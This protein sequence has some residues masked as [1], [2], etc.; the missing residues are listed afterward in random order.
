MGLNRI[1]FVTRFTSLVWSESYIGSG[2]FQ[3]VTYADPA[4]R[5][6]LKNGRFF[7]LPG[8]DTLMLIQ[9]VEERDG[10]LWIRGAE[11]K[12]L[13][14]SRV[15]QGTVVCSGNV[16]DACRSLVAQTDPYPVFGLAEK[17][18]LA[19]VVQSQRTYPTVYEAVYTWLS[20][21]GYGFRFVH[22]K[23]AKKLL[24][25]VYEGQERR[26]IRFSEQF[27]NLYNLTRISSEAKWKN[28]AFVGGAGEGSDRVFVVVGET[29]AAD[30]NRREMYV[31]ARDIQ[32][33]EGQSDEEYRELLRARGREKLAETKKSLEI[34]FDISSNDFGKTFFLGDMVTAILSDGEKHTVRIAEYEEVYENDTKSTRLVLGN[35]ILG[36]YKK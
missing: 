14:D 22:N 2:R 35:P 11:A 10:N 29:D 3:L 26:G 34:E 21:V 24:F 33:F 31:D 19:A 9:S 28:V 17:Q 12:V 13:L 16:E 4:G 15:A 25:H 5:E 23:Q 8:K 20:S 18:G 27:G 32:P 1:G 30:E 6:L 36:G 7:G